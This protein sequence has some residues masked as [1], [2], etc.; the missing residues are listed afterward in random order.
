MIVALALYMKAPV[1]YLLS[2]VSEVFGGTGWHRSYLIDLAVTHF[3]EW[4]L[5][6][7]AY[8]AHWAPGGQVLVNDPNNMDITN[9][10]IAEGLGGGIWKLGLFIAM[11]VFCFKTVGY[12]IR[13][14]DDV[15][16]PERI[17][18]YAIGVSLFAHCVSFVSISYFDQIIIMW[19][20]TLANGA[21]LRQ[22]R[23][24][25]LESVA[26]PEPALT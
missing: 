5:V 3:N 14:K 19:F 22:T 25:S 20:W 21:M 10:Y 15:S 8:T 24:M 7:S 23:P 18:V 26:E 6:G 1:W 16:L 17:F 4:W 13:A 12:W 9:H 2:R 11:I